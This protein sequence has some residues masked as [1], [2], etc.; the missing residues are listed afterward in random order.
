MNKINNIIFKLR[1]LRLSVRRVNRWIQ[2]RRIDLLEYALKNGMF[3]VR[4]RA[5]E[6]LLELESTSSLPLLVDAIDDKI[7]VVSLAA[8]DAIE[9]LDVTGSH[10]MRILGKRAYWVER[11]RL[12]HETAARKIS[13]YEI[14][15]WNRPS[16]QTRENLRKM[17]QKPMNIGKWF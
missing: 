4:K 8:M 10:Q 7:M 9:I 11:E 6:G 17:L 1:L 3:D 14:H 15:K 12:E 2:N 13:P 5:V 16:G